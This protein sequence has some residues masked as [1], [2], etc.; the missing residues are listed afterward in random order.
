MGPSI[1]VVR[2]IEFVDD[3]ESGL[4]RIG[5]CFGKLLLHKGCDIVRLRIGSSGSELLTFVQAGNDELKELK[6]ILNCGKRECAGGSGKAA[7][8]EIVSGSL[9]SSLNQWRPAWGSASLT[10]VLY[11]PLMTIGICFRQQQQSRRLR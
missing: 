4:R 2:M 3:S 10:L 1:G 6:G 11:G 8:C 7:N 5:P 9:S